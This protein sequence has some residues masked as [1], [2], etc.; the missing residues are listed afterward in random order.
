MF[1]EA[2]AAVGAAKKIVVIQAEN[3]DGDSLGSALAL[4]ELLG[5]LGKEIALYCP[6]DIPKYLR[7][8]KGWDRI[9]NEL[10]KEFDLSIIVDTASATLMERAIVPENLAKL[11]AKPCIVIDHH[12]T[13]G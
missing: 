1:K 5:D 10:P 7:Y 3:P 13:E 2:R 6:V 4:E 9:V 8:T 11:K 12:L